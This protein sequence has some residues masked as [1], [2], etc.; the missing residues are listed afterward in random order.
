MMPRSAG[1]GFAGAAVFACGGGVCAK[2]TELIGKLNVELHSFRPKAFLDAQ[3]ALQ[4][5]EHES[6]VDSP[7]GLFEHGVRNH[8]DEW[9]FIVR[10][11]MTLYRKLPRSIDSEG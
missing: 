9:P 7:T 8:G 10:S 4:V 5:R 6:R 11:E 3:A 2:L 1:E